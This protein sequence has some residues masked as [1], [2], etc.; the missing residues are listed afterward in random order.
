MNKSVLTENALKLPKSKKA[1]KIELMFAIEQE[2]VKLR[3][4]QKKLIYD[5]FSKKC[6][7]TIKNLCFFASF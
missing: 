4:L 7:V 1:K 3:F 5:D 6:H 2:Q